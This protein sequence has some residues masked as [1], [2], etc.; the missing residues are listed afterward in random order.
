[1][2]PNFSVK[3]WARLFAPHWCRDKHDIGIVAEDKGR[4]V[5]FHGHVCSNRPVKGRLERFTN[6]SSWY[7]LKEYRRQGLGSAMLE[8]ATE[9]P[10]TTYTV[11]SL[12]PKR[13]EFIKKLGIDLLDTKRYLWR[14]DGHEYEN[15]ELLNDPK[16]MEMR[17]SPDEMRVLRDHHNSKALPVLVSTR[18]SQC[19]LLLSVAKKK[20]GLIYYDVLYRSNPGLFTDRV[21]DIAQALLPDGD[22]VL[23]ADSR[24]V[25]GDLH[26]AEVE[27]MPSPRFYK[28]SHVDPADIDLAYSEIALLDLK[29]D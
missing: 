12:S 14:K 4:I 23:A 6:F 21:A 18:C 20:D 11:C 24:F 26:G 17:T 22:V 10:N 8:M 13:V 7:I 3:K 19:L 2:N 25:E 27:E 5:G 16:K 28:S 1:M 29:L 15:L 9:A